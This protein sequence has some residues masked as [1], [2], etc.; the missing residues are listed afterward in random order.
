MLSKRGLEDEKY[1][2]QGRCFMAEYSMTYEELKNFIDECIDNSESRV[3][4]SKHKAEILAAITTDVNDENSSDIKEVLSLWENQIGMPSELLLGTRYISIKDC[5]ITFIEV[6][7]CSGLVDAIISAEPVEQITVGVLSGVVWPLIHLFTSV[8]SLN[9]LDFCI[10]M[11]AVSHFK[12]HK[13]F[14]EKDLLDWFPHGENLTCNIDNPKW[15]CEFI[16]NDE[17]TIIAEGG[18]EH[19]LDSLMEKGL[20]KKERHDKQNFYKFSY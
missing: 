1:F 19:A 13:P 16:E 7:C 4:L 8:S 3:N 9:D 18:I 2:E 17:C 11:Q 14:T 6:A 20:L 15:D 12:E 10:Y 5:V